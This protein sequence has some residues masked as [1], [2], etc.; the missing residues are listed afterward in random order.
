MPITDT[1]KKV[2][3]I[4]VGK[5]IMEIACEDLTGEI[6]KGLADGS[7]TEFSAPKYGITN[8]ASRRFESFT[9]LTG[10]NLTGITDIPGYTAYSCLNLKELIL[11]PNITKVGSYAFYRTRYVT[12]IDIITN[13]LELETNAFCESKINRVI[14]ILSNIGDHSF[15]TVDLKELDV[16][17]NGK[18]ENYAFDSNYNLAILK[19]NPD[20]II[21]SLGN[22]VF[23]YIGT[24]VRQ[25]NPEYWDLD[26]RNSTFTS[27][28]Q[29]CFIGNGTGS[30]LKNIKF[31]FNEKVSSIGTYAFQY[32][33]GFRIYWNSVPTL[34]NTNTFSGA[35]NYK[36]F[37][38]YQLAHTAKTATN[39]SSST[40]GIVDSIYGYAEAGTFALNETLPNTDADGYA[41]TWYSDEDLTQEVSTVTDETATYYCI[42]SERTHALLN[43]TSFQADVVV[44]DGTTNYSTGDLVP[45]GANLTITAAGEGTNTQKYI[46]E[47]NDTDI[48]SGYAYTVGAADISIVC[49]YW[50]GI[51]LPV[52][53]TFADNTPTQIKLG[54]DNGLHR[55]LWNVGDT[56]TIE[57]TDGTQATVRLTDTIANRYEKTDGSGY[58]NGVLEFTTILKNAVMNSSAT[59]AGG[60][61]ATKMNTETMA[62]IFALLPT[63]WQEI[64]SEVK[65]GSATSGSDSTIVY[66]NNKCFLPSAQEVYNSYTSYAY[67]EGGQ[68]FEYY[69]GTANSAKIKKFNNSAQY[70][71]LRS[72]CRGGSV[73]FCGVTTSGSFSHDTASHSNG[74]SACLAI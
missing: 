65:I 53:E 6:I 44:S 73:T 25:D 61:P 56:K 58:T 46:F 3:K 59:N 55:I 7:L 11:D 74:V 15:S 20:S 33:D 57:L 67:D 64:V 4:T 72:P 34:S 29:Y 69:D 68:V 47:L 32:S 35:T 51:N 24:A 2:R 10:L 39:W 45:V 60:W 70:W 1:S 66:T 71:W 30:K 14:G 49:I 21:T 9:N 26:F 63:E 52:N 19:I 41:L 36:N 5:D 13:N 28:G 48:T 62:E 23:R 37:F 54:I 42:V 16:T 27:I 43:V 18:I 8:L 31:Q 50:D 38:P 40:N 22:Y 17:I 12:P